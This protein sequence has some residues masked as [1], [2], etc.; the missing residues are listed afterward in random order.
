MTSLKISIHKKRKKDKKYKKKK[1][2]RASNLSKIFQNFFN[3]NK[4]LGMHTN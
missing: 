2:M 4:R 3:Q 1:E